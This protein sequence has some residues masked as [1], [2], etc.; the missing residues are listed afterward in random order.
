MCTGNSFHSPR[1]RQQQILWKWKWMKWC[2]GQRFVPPPRPSHCRCCTRCSHRLGE[3][4]SELTH[5]TALN[6]SSRQSTLPDTV[7]PTS[8]ACPSALSCP[9]ILLQVLTVTLLCLRSIHLSSVSPVCLLTFS[10]LSALPPQVVHY[11]GVHRSAAAKQ[12]ESSALPQTT[13]QPGDQRSHED[14]GDAAQP[15]GDRAR[16]RL[17]TTP[18]P[19]HYPHSATHPAVPSY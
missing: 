8:F 4:C 15:A 19:A 14:G 2:E 9:H 10:P 13:I 12:P 6:P 18:P 11:H 17:R 1:V 5:P 16:C 3:H 7:V